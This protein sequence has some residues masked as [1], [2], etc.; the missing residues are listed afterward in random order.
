MATSVVEMQKKSEPQE[1]LRLEIKRVIKASRQRVFD[2]WTRPETI[3]LWFE[4][5]GFTMAEAN[6]DAREGG[7]YRFTMNGVC[8]EDGQPDL[9]QSSMVTGRYVRVEPYD[10]LAFTWTSCR[11]P[12]EESLVTI[13]LKDVAGGTEMTLTHDRFLTVESRDRHFGG[14]SSVVPKLQEF[15]ERA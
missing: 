5:R 14:W 10:V 2:A 12:E 8:G 3:R 4:P 9:S 11:N 7:E 13:G 15:F 6:I 1:N